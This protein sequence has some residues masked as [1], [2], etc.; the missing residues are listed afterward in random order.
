MAHGRDEAFDNDDARMMQTLADF[1]A[2]AMRHIRQQRELM[3]QATA[4]AA[5]SMANELAHQINN[6]LQGLTNVL[7]L[8]AEGQ[9]GSDS[10]ALAKE[11]SQDLSRLSLLVKK[12]LA[13]PGN[14]V[15]AN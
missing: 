7:Y 6:P 13:L 9:S 3:E 5:A 12:L 8:A 11:A 4:A 15:R 10:R 14:S 2:M 1:A